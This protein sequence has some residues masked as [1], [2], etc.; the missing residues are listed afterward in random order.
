MT[1][2]TIMTRQLQHGPTELMRRCHLSLNSRSVL[3]VSYWLRSGRPQARVRTKAS[4]R[5]LI[6]ASVGMGIALSKAS[7]IAK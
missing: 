4:K 7:R 2:T 1:R 6:S 3:M 5:R